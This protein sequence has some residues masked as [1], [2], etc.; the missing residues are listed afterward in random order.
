MPA[1][2][3]AVHEPSK[4][5]IGQTLFPRHKGEVAPDD[6]SRRKQSSDEH[7]GAKV[8]V[9]MSVK[10]VW[11]CPIEAMKLAYLSG[12]DGFEGTNQSGMKDCDSQGSPEVRGETVLVFHELCRKV[13]GGQGGCKIQ[14][15]ASVDVMLSGHGRSAFGIRHEDHSAHGRDGS[16]A[17]ALQ[18]AGG[19][20]VIP[21]PIVGVHDER[22]GR[23][24]IPPVDRRLG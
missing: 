18:G 3:Y 9:M 11:A 12:D 2:Q 8:D 6:R 14:V 1:G 10:A 21:P 23:T 15:Q 13:R 22:A 5:T 20:L 16:K 24:P 17:D 4:E 7:V 19:R